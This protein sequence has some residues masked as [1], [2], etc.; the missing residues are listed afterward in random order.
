M[1]GYFVLYRTIQVYFGLSRTDFKSL[2]HDIKDYI[3][4]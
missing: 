2:V 1:Q 3:G 4:L